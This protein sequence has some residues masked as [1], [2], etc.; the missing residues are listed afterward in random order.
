M[1]L[2]VLFILEFIFDRRV[3]VRFALFLDEEEDDVIARI[4][5]ADFYGIFLTSLNNKKNS[6]NI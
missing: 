3:L 1:L 2:F 6:K 5:V 4:F